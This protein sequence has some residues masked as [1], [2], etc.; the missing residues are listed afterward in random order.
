VTSILCSRRLI[1][2]DGWHL[3]SGIARPSVGTSS[4]EFPI[5]FSRRSNKLGYLINLPTF[6]DPRGILTVVDQEVPFAIKRV[7]YLYGVTQA[8]GGHRH[9]KTVQALICLNGS[10]EIFIHNGKE[11][12]TVLLDSPRKLL[13]VE[14]EDW[15]TMD[16]FSQGAILLVLASEAYDRNDYIDEEYSE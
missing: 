13:I 8:R 1:R 10:C 11:K 4:I 14:A 5:G 16:K 3:G 15:H 7:Y 9:K 12:E 2:F 6:E